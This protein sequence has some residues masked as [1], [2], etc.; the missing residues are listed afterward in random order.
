M[1]AA[2]GAAE[3]SE[4]EAVAV[5]DEAFD[6]AADGAPTEEP[7]EVEEEPACTA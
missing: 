5:D 7:I 2:E 1:E 4:P 3:G 6:A